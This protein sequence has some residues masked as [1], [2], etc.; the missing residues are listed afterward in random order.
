MLSRVQRLF[1][2]PLAVVLSLLVLPSPSWAQ[3]TQG[4]SS[5]DDRGGIGIGIKGGPLFATFESSLATNPFEKRT[6]LIGGLF[7]GGNRPGLVGVMVEILYAKKSATVDGDPLDL[8]YLEVPVLLRV[9]FGSSNINRGVSG[10]VIAGPAVNLNLKARQAD[11][12]VKDNVEAADLEI[13]FGGGVEISR[14]IIEGRY[15]K[16]IR[17][18]GKNLDISEE[19][20]TKAFALL[21]GVRFN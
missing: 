10:Y 16:G 12:D 7:I 13:H 21:F 1:L 20:K 8:Y 6:G 19:I 14:F 2:A 3:Q 4:V 5:D 18:I 9:N 15:M 11:F 17:N